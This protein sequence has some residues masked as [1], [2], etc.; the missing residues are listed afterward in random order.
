[1]TE[2]LRTGC[3]EE[4]IKM[5]KRVVEQIEEMTAE[6]NE[7]DFSPC[8]E[9]N[10]VFKTSPVFIDECS[11][12]GDVYLASVA[13]ENCH[14]TE[15]CL[16]VAEVNEN[17]FVFVHALDQHEMPYTSSMNEITCDLVSEYIAPLPPSPP[18][19]QGWVG[20]YRGI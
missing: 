16:E 11:Q 6:F 9:V 15:K 8:E 7:D 12:V 13:A 17:V 4:I 2:S 18:L 1:M 10:I 3:E 19:P 5:R 20:I 14:A